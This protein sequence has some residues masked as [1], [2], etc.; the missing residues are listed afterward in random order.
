[1][2]AADEAP[3]GASWL[4]DRLGWPTIRAM[5]ASRRMPRQGLSHYLGGVTLALFVL[6]VASGILLLLYYEPD[7]VR[8]HPSVQRIIGE[9]PYGNLVRATHVWASDL[10]VGFLL[11]HLF[12]VVL[13]RSFRSPR[14]LAWLSGLVL[15]FL[16]IGLA[17]TGAILPWSQAAQSD[18][19]VGSD[20]A[21]YV[22]LVGDHLRRFMRGGEEVTANTLG[23]AFGFHVAALPAALTLVI[24]LHLLLVSRR[25]PTARAPDELIPLYP[26]FLVRG[27]ALTTAVLVVVMTLVVFIERPLG[28]A[29]D[30]RASAPAGSHPP[31]YFLPVHEVVRIAPKEMLGMDG[32]RFLVGM[33]SAFALVA[34]ALPFIDRRGSKI[35]AW[36]AVGLLLI[37][38]LLSSRA[39][40]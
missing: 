36:I 29:G 20:L 28:V 24:A 39:L 14:E 13:R 10:F 18:A 11:A 6:Q 9:L 23:H 26:D 12:T 27:A 32:A 8:A 25:R 7:A 38:L 5:L 2:N 31:W 33:A 22:P 37:L 15:L 30:L 1:M 21:K 35:T 34:M 40:D 4:G 17:F 3:S 16:G 19:R